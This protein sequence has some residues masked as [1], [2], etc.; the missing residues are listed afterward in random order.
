MGLILIIQIHLTVENQA[1]HVL[2][3]A[4][5]TSWNK[6]ANLGNKTTPKQIQECWPILRFNQHDALFNINE[7]M[8]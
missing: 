4:Q 7:L 8:Q 5:I 2:K 1:L 3:H 6:D